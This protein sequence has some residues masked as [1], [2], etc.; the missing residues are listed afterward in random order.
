M[1]ITHHYT[2]RAGSQGQT[3]TDTNEDTTCNEASDAATR[4]EALHERSDNHKCGSRS[5]ADT[6]TEVI[7]Y[8][9]T[10]E[11]TSDNGTHSIS[12]IDG[13]NRLAV[14]RVEVGDLEE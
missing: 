9:T 5:H 6:S 10:E 4:S 7:G 13:T 12:S 11:E 1:G 14:R 8:W 3:L 2:Y